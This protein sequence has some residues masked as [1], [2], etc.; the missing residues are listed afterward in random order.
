MWNM[1]RKKMNRMSA[2]VAAF[3]TPLLLLGADGNARAAAY[4][5][6]SW[7]PSRWII[8]HRGGPALYPEEGYRG[9]DASAASHFTLEAD[10]RQLKDGLWVLSHDDTVD[11]TIR[12]LSGLVNQLTAAQWLAPTTYL[13]PGR[14][15][16]YTRDHPA[17]LGGFL[18]RYGGRYPILLE[19]KAGSVP[20]FI[21]MIKSHHLESSVMVQTFNWRTALQFKAAGLTPMFLMGADLKKSPANEWQIAAAGIHYIGVNKNMEGSQVAE[22]RRAALVVVSYTVDTE[23][24]FLHDLGE[25]MNGSFSND[26]WVLH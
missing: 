12:G 10:A 14:S 15:N 8:A 1:L 16:T 20:S 18:L 5:P 9:Y 21:N 3:T 11:R 26:P 24:S 4:A 17:T 6:F 23:S 7:N 2:V 25:G 13:K 19:L 22:L